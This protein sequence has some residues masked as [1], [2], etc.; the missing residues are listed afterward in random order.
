MSIDELDFSIERG[1]LFIEN[2]QLANGGFP[3]LLAQTTNC[4]VED[5]LEFDDGVK[6][7]KVIL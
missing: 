3:C 6:K 7:S 4:I 5:L 1:L 2:R